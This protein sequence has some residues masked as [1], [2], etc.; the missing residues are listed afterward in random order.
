M[1]LS[2]AALAKSWVLF[3]VA[4]WRVASVALPAAA[5]CG[6]VRQAVWGSAAL[7]PIPTHSGYYVD[8]SVLN[9]FVAASIFVLA[10]L[11]NGIMAD[12]KESERIPGEIEAAFQALLAHVLVSA[13]AKKFEPLPELR[14]L[15]SMLRTVARCVDK[16]AP[17]AQCVRELMAADV[18][19]IAALDSHGVMAPHYTGFTNIIRSRLGRA[20]VISDTT[21]LLPFYSLFDTLVTIVHILLVITNFTS[22]YAGVTNACVFSF[23]FVYLG[24]LVRDLDDPFGYP[25]RYQERCVDAA[26]RLPLSVSSTITDASSIDFSILTVSFASMLGAELERLGEP[27]SPTP[28]SVCAGEGEVAG[29]GA[30]A[31][32]VLIVKGVTGKVAAA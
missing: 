28:D 9:G 21:F 11:L 19:L 24:V 8:A 29:A 25:D 32:G 2:N 22:H 27:F 10:I 14:A 13:R 23:L 15:R 31:G 1:V 26:R 4:R 17:Y 30:G 6:G 20:H 18:D 12:Y 3:V 16:S 5:I 7:L